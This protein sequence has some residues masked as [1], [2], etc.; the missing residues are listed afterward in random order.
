[1]CFLQLRRRPLASSAV[2]AVAHAKE[3][4]V[5]A[6]EGTASMV[7]RRVAPTEQGYRPNSFKK[8]TLD[9]DP[10]HGGFFLGLQANRREACPGPRARR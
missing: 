2:T 10:D 3:N 9:T 4:R 5:P 1:M 8:S 6:G 7:C